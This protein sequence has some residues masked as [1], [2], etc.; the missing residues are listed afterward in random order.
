MK[1]LGCRNYTENE[2]EIQTP[3]GA[4]HEENYH[5]TKERAEGHLNSAYLSGSVLKFS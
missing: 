4:K 2:K 1:K 5:I 3:G